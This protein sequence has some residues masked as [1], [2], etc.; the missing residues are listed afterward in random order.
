MAIPCILRGPTSTAFFLIA[1]LVVSAVVPRSFA[2]TTKKKKSKA[3]PKAHAHTVKKE[4]TSDSPSDTWF[5]RYSGPNLRLEYPTMDSALLGVLVGGPPPSS[6]TPQRVVEQQGKI[7]PLLGEVIRRPDEP[8]PRPP[9]GPTPAPYVAGPAVPPLPDLAPATSVAREK[10]ATGPMSVEDRRFAGLYSKTPP[11]RG[12]VGPHQR[13]DYVPVQ[14]EVS[15]PDRWRQGFSDY[16]QHVRGASWDPYE[17]NVLKG[18]FPLWGDRNFLVLTGISDTLFEERHLPTPSNIPAANQGEFAT[19][20]NPKQHAFRQDF[21]FSALLFNGDTAFEPPKWQVKITA[22][23]NVDNTI[24][25]AELGDV[26]PDSRKGTDR[27][28]FDVAIQEFFA[29]ARLAVTSPF[30]DFTSVRLGRQFF[31]SDFR[32]FIFSNFNQGIR[33][34]GNGAANRNSFNLVYFDMVEYESNSG[35]LRGDPSPERG[36]HVFIAN[37]YRQDAFD[38]EGYTLGVNFHMDQDDPSFVFDTNG[39]L[40]RPDPVGNFR[41]HKVEARYVGLVG[42]GH[43]GWLNVSHA[44]YHA[45]GRDSENPLAGQKIDINANMGALEASVDKDWIR[46]KLSLFWSEGDNDPT[47]NKGKGFDSILDD[48]NFA[49]GEYSFYVRQG[50]GL[51]GVGLKQRLSLIPDLRTSKLQ[52]QAN[53]VNPGLRLAGVGVD[54]D[55]TPKLKALINLNLLRFDTT[56]ALQLFI[57]QKTV[58]TGLGIDYSLGV[59][60]RPNLSQNIV[61]DLGLGGFMPSDGFSAIYGTDKGLYQAFTNIKLAF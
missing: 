20:G 50:I 10:L 19:F 53:F 54:L 43:I 32:G 46:Y 57:F 59:N 60:Y 56:E 27:H 13:V 39:F 36:Q 52:G 25:L 24:R 42:D 6:P 47:D 37:A 18:D 3:K 15:R 45:F 35:L 8:R 61:V 31:N 58:P 12:W 7:E 5:A 41:P 22:D 34:F 4:S 17:Q 44:F 29:E 1:V 28:T 16:K 55:I 14:S 2:A 26:N 48:P 40:A 49:G 33:L 9:P 51:Q 11:T 23:Y 30:Y 21:E 38:I